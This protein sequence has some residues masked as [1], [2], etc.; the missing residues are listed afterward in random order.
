MAQLIIAFLIMLAAFLGGYLV[1]AIKCAYEND[2]NDLARNLELVNQR[3]DESVKQNYEFEKRLDAVKGSRNPY[4]TNAALEDAI[5]IA[6]DNRANLEYQDIRLR[7]LMTV[8]G[9]RGAT[10]IIMTKTG[11][12][13]REVDMEHGFHLNQEV[14]TP[15][16]PGI[17]QGCMK[18]DGEELIIIFHS[19][20]DPRVSEKVRLDRLPGIM[21]RRFYPVSQLE[22]MDGHSR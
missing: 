15:N 16:G 17:I 12:T 11:Q 4:L 10:R 7:Q 22:P 6:M 20:T 8:L 5:A 2:M 3:L 1:H 14:K 19:R 13:G 9:R 18:E 21:I